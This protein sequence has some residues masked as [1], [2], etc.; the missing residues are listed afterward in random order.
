MIS[1]ADV[2]RA[3][4]K[5]RGR[6]VLFSLAAAAFAASSLLDAHSGMFFRDVKPWS[7][8]SAS[9]FYWVIESVLMAL[10]ILTGGIGPRR[11]RRLM[12]DDVTIRNRSR[13]LSCGF[14]AALV[15]ALAVLAVP[16]VSHITAAGA[17]FV[18]TA[19]ALFVSLAVFAVLELRATSDV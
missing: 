8:E 10:L 3:D 15:S 11:I 16:Q 19:S 4:R 9:R 5:S 1:K 6:A 14:C 7:E 18:V 17:A 12:N 13:A 2:E